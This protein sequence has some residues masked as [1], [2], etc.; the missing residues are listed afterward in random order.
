VRA[1]IVVGNVPTKEFFAITRVLIADRLPI[2][3]GMVPVSELLVRFSVD[4]ITI[5]PGV[6]K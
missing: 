6:T 1:H 5:D 4:I 3:G 2:F